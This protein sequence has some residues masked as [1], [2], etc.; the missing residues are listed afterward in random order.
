MVCRAIKREE[1]RARSAVAIRRA[2]GIK[3][4]SGAIF[5]N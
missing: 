5:I 3:K 4:A 1:A 2:E